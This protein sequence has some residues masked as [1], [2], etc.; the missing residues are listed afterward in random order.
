MKTMNLKISLMLAAAAGLV[1]T[2][3]APPPA[4]ADVMECEGGAER[5]EIYNSCLP[6]FT[7]GCDPHDERIIKLGGASVALRPEERP[8]EESDRNPGKRNF[9]PVLA[10]TLTVFDRSITLRC[11]PVEDGNGHVLD[12]KCESPEA[13]VRFMFEYDGFFI[14]DAERR[15]H[16]SGFT[17][18]LSPV[19]G[20]KAQADYARFTLKSPCRFSFQP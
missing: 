15:Y 11:T 12:Y 1:L 13:T 3:T 5:V 8:A 17:L 20:Q 2:G 4:H 19:P 7:W 6:H 18:R 16:L 10:G 14:P 9:F